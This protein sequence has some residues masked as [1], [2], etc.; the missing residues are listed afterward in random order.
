MVKRNIP[1]VGLKLK[2]KLFNICILH[3]RLHTFPKL[4]ID[5][6]PK[7]KYFIRIKIN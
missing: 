7:L 2:K 4:V 3:S 6:F 5:L 1:T